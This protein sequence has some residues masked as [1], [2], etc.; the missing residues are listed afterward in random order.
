MLPIRPTVCPNA[1]AGVLSSEMSSEDASEWESQHSDGVV[2][3]EEL[4]GPAMDHSEQVD[5]RPP[6]PPP[7]PEGPK[8]KRGKNPE[9]RNRGNKVTVASR[10]KQFP[11]HFFQ[12]GN[13]MWCIVC[14]VPVDYTQVPFAKSHLGSDRHGERKREHA[15]RREW[16]GR[17]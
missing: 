8:K 17:F 3:D 14:Q 4:V 9:T 13:E 6:P 12:Q 2:D 1:C 5:S 15:S 7:P 10:M 16:S 11:G